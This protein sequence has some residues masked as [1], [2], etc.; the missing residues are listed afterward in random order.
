MLKVRPRFSHGIEFIQLSEL[1]FDQAQN[2]K[3]WLSLN[4]YLK[5]NENNELIEDCIYYED[6]EYW[7]D[8][9]FDKL[10]TPEYDF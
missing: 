4:S 9:Q 6:Y 3:N 5:I 8:H 1:P 2:L 10:D 7:Y